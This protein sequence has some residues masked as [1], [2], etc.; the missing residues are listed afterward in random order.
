MERKLH[1]IAHFSGGIEWIKLLNSKKNDK[2]NNERYGGMKKKSMTLE[3]LEWNKTRETNPVYSGQMSEQHKLCA[4]RA[5]GLTINQ[6]SRCSSIIRG[7]TIKK[8]QFIRPLKSYRR[9]IIEMF[10]GYPA[11]KVWCIF[12]F[13][14]M[15]HK[16]DISSYRARK[17]VHKL[18]LGAVMVDREKQ[19]YPEVKRST[20]AK[21]SMVMKNP[22]RKHKINGR[23]TEAFKDSLGHLH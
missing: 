8:R 21:K 10:I 1:N 6:L 16:M 15:R 18:H 11:I 17:L 22:Q 20:W 5:T 7:I 13:D 9:S 14:R 2:N 3:W 12:H 23:Y 19:L 4:S